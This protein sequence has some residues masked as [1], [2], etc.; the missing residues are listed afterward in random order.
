MF[1]CTCRLYTLGLKGTK[2]LCHFKGINFQTDGG[3]RIPTVLY[4][5]GKI[6][7]ILL[8]LLDDGILMNM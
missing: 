4:A 8:L 3:L 2:N 5:R 6:F 7:D 1:K